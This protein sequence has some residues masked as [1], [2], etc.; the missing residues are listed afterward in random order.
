MDLGDGKSTWEVR[1][2]TRFDVD[3]ESAEMILEFEADRLADTHDRGFHPGG[4]TAGYRWYLSYGALTLS[5]KQQLKHDEVAR[6]TDFKDRLGLNLGH[7]AEQL[8]QRG[9]RFGDL[10]D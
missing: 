6:R 2:G 5:H 3:V 1:T 8:V 9:V 7:D 10:P 4:I